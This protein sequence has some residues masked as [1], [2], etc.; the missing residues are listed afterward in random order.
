MQTWSELQAYYHKRFGQEHVTLEFI[1]LTLGMQALGL[2]PGKFDRQQKMDLIQL[3]SNLVLAEQGYYQ[4]L[5]TDAQGW[6]HFK[7]V[8]ALPALNPFEQAAFLQRA[9]LQ[10]FSTHVQTSL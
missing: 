9:V 4:Q 10:Y 7:L 2:P 6:P 1:L 3:G 5:G 8:K